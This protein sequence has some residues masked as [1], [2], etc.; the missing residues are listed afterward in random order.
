MDGRESCL[1][2]GIVVSKAR[3][4]DESGE[5]T[6]TYLHMDHMDPVSRGGYDPSTY[7]LDLEDFTE[8]TLRNVVYCCSDC[9]LRKNDLLF[10]EWPKLIPTE[11][12]QLA[13]DIYRE[14]NGI[15]PEDFVP[16]DDIEIRISIL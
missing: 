14:R 7:D 5:V 15:E 4:Y 2:C 11:N 1:Y 12:R 9:N 6:K 13:R 3:D 10:V 16:R 8:N